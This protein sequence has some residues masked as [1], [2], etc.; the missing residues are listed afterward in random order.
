MNQIM[1]INLEEIL[2]RI[3]KQQCLAKIL[4]KEADTHMSSRGFEADSNFTFDDYN[5]FTLACATGGSRWIIITREVTI[6]IK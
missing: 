2:Q 5:T 1:K 4:V 6:A 3:D